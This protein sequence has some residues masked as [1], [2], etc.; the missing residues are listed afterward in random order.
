MT[1]LAFRRDGSD[2]VQLTGAG[3]PVGMFAD[4]E[5]GCEKYQLPEGAEILLYSDGAFELPLPEGAMWSLSD[6]VELCTV[7]SRSGDW[8][9]EYLTEEL[10][11][12]TVAGL[13]NDD[14]SLLRLQ[15]H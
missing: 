10:K 2:P 5:F 14:C 15:F 6:F 3:L 7:L 4:T 11:A 9:L 13:F 1:A 8:T 12:R